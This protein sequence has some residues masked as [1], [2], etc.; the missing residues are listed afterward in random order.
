MVALSDDLKTLCTELGHPSTGSGQTSGKTLP[1]RGELVEPRFEIVSKDGYFVN[2][3]TKY[4]N[5][6]TGAWVV[7]PISG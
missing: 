2:L 7:Q 1:V 6:S 3:V 4:I 5:G